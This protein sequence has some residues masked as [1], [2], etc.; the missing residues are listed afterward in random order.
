MLEVR[1][2][3]DA[4]ADS[5]DDGGAD[6]AGINNSKPENVSAANPAG[7]GNDAKTEQVIRMI[8]EMFDGEI[9][10]QK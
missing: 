7:P 10:T 8:A 1:N 5:N 2:G 4:D 6:C 9:L 3:G